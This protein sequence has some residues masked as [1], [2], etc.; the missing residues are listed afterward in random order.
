MELL[1]TVLITLFTLAILVSIHEYGH[2]WVARRCGIKVLRFSVGFG[3]PLYRWRDKL[4]T[5][6]VIAAIPLGGYVKM[7]DEREGEVPEELRHM[8]FNNKPVGHRLA[9]VAAG[10]LANFLLAIIVYW[11]VFVAGVSGVAPIIDKVEAGSVA[12]LAGLEVGQEIVA[13]D[14]E[15]TPTWEALHLRLLERIGDSGEI[16]FTVKYANSDLTYSSSATVETWLSGVEVTDLMAGIGIE[17]YRPKLI[18]EIDQVVAGSPA[19][20]A[21]FKTGDIVVQADEQPIAQWGDWVDYVRER[22]EQAIAVQ[23]LRNE[24][25][26]SSLLTPE[27]KID[28]QGQAYGQVG[29]GVKWPEWPPELRRDFQYSPVTALT[30][31]LKRTW[32]MSAFTLQSI[33]KMLMGLISP[34][35]LSGPITIAKV[36]S[37]SANS[38]LSS[39]LSFL[40]LLSVSLG[41]LNLLPIPVLDGG[42]ILFGVVE[43]ITGRPV[44]DR[45]QAMGYRLGFFIIISMM[46]LALYNDIS[47]L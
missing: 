4:D 3:K 35:N 30:A 46:M 24:Q 39:Y 19:A 23:Y 7:L 5:E 13:V 2:F 27:R 21:G 38:G 37:A 28:E 11:F 32:D 15:A 45:I 10:P 8:A 22:P 12:E 34:K 44:S 16:E 29:M 41:V 25:V 20:V 18:A 43:L 31:S 17:L 6:Y 47:R 42:H 1:Q 26:L 14:G 9:T 40:A 36:A 33:K